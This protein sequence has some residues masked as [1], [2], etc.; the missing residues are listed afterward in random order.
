[1]NNRYG[2]RRRR[3]VEIKKL[4]SCA[5]VEG[6]SP[7]VIRAG[8]GIS[9]LGISTM[10]LTQGSGVER[11]TTGVPELDRMTDGGLFRDSVVLISGATGLGK[12]LL[13]NHFVMGG[14]NAG[15]KSMFLAFEE[16]REQV[17]RNAAAFGLDLKEAERSGKIVLES[18]YPEALGM[19]EHLLRI[20]EVVRREQPRRLVID[21]LSALERIGPQFA[22]RQFLIGLAAFVKQNR[23]T[24]V[25]TAG[26][27]SLGDEV[28]ISEQHIST[29]NDTIIMLRYIDTQGRMERAL[30]LLKMRGS[31][32][33]REHRRY[34]ITDSGMVLAGPKGDIN[35]LRTGEAM[36]SD[37]SDIDPTSDLD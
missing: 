13:C 33:A 7:F 29:L 9:V 28:S 5:H 30:T 11:T 1:R 34:R 22:F 3:S 15:E 36:T 19:E 24:T 6:E 31:M 12:T 32:H 10:Q 27:G 8:R 16:S 2:E 23:V 14:A 25:L 35:R 37:V 18:L 20:Q 17:F 4:R 26:G 21:S